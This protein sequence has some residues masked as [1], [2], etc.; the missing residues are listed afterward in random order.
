MAWLKKNATAKKSAE[1]KLKPEMNFMDFCLRKK[2]NH[3]MA[4]GMYFFLSL[5]V[6]STAVGNPNEMSTA[7]AKI[8]LKKYCGGFFL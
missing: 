7:V 4:R 6:L 8:L 5:L 3:L 2:S 1:D